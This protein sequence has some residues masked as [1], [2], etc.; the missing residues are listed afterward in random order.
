MSAWRTA[1]RAACA[2][3]AL[4]K[5]FLYDTY[6]VAEARAWGARF[7]HWSNVEHRHS[8]IGYVTPTQRHE[9]YSRARAVNP[10]R[11]SGAT[12]DWTPCGAVTLNPERDSVI[13]VAV[14]GQDKRIAR[15]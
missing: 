14:V 6:Q 7:L 10:R 2:L 3:P 15:A 12:R 9:V 13:D 8:G 1:A 5:D 4:R 11:W